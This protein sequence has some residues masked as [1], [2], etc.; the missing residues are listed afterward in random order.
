MSRCKRCVDNDIHTSSGE[1]CGVDC[2]SHH[3]EE[4]EKCNCACNLSLIEKVGKLEA[5]VRE[6]E[7]DN[8][9]LI[10]TLKRASSQVNKRPVV[11]KR[12]Q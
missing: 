2:Q 11:T 12:E 6:L 10:L 1:C 8:E 3:R 4:T 9:A 7:E 5:R